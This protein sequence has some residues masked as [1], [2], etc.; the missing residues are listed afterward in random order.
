MLNY[1]SSLTEQAPSQGSI[2]DVITQNEQ[3]YL[4]HQNLKLRNNQFNYLVNKD[5]KED[6]DKFIA[7]STKDLTPIE[8][9]DS[10]LNS[11]LATTVDLL[12]DK[13]GELSMEL[14][15]GD[16]T[17]K[18]EI[19]TSML[20][21]NRA[22]KKL[23]ALSLV[24]ADI[25]EKLNKGE[26]H[27]DPKLRE[28]LRGLG[29]LTNE[30]INI[31]DKGNISLMIPNEDGTRRQIPI[32]QA[33]KGVDGFNLV[34]K[35]DI[36]KMADDVAK[37]AEAKEVVR[38]EG[39]EQTTKKGIS[40]EYADAQAKVLIYGTDNKDNW[41]VNGL[42]NGAKS[43]LYE[44]GLNPKEPSVEMFN[45]LDDLRQTLS[46]RIINSKAQ[47]DEET[48]D[49]AAEDRDLSREETKINNAFNRSMR[50][51]EFNASQQGGNNNN[52]R[53]STSKVSDSDSAVFRNYVSNGKN[54][55]LSKA[56]TEVTPVDIGSL[57]LNKETINNVKVYGLA[58]DGNTPVIDYQYN[59]GD[60][61]SEILS[62]EYSI[63][64]NNTAERV[65]RA[66]GYS[67]L[68]QA[69]K[70]TKTNNLP[71]IDSLPNL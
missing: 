38:Y 62:R 16:G 63:V 20:N 66:M 12:Q 32:D 28:Y 9:K 30:D 17:K 1:T 43:Y 52:N 56:I 60:S 39:Y 54:R 10:D 34:P 65:A 23:K 4:Q 71:S 36:F 57:N 51:R 53:N 67:N 13:A 59:S 49:Y 42:S 7:N 15:Y 6:R 40:P 55:K 11:F 14:Q 48:F 69:K 22:G 5:L 2:A 21:I 70:A 58:F 24:G 26:V 47:T 8:V 29:N 31:D 19:E 61:D 33:L 68:E 45:V 44:R 18:R 64:S 37:N 35:A 25:A 3:S 46:D 41:S 27:D 50:L